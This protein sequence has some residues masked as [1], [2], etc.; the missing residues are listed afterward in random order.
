MLLARGKAASTALWVREVF[1]RRLV[2][3]L[4]EN[5]ATSSLVTSALGMAIEN[6]RWG[7]MSHGA[8]LAFVGPC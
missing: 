1:G 3:W 2:G 5:T 6:R 4:I 7:E 8:M